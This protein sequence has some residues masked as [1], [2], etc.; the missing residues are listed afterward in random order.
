MIF[1]LISA[2]I[3]LGL[4]V[5][6]HELG[7]FTV[8]KAVGIKVQEFSVGMGPKIFQKRKG[9]TDYSLRGVPIGGYVKMEGE[10]E[11][12]EDERSF[13][14]KPILSRIAVLIAGSFMNFLLAIII[15]TGIFYTIGVVTTDIAGVSDDAPAYEA[16]IEAGDKI[17][18]IDGETART[19]SA[20]QNY[21]NLSEEDQIQV[22]VERGEETLEKTVGVRVDEELNRR[23]IGVEFDVEQSLGAAVAGSFRETRTIVVEIFNFFTRIFTGEADV[24]QE[25]A[26]PVGIVSLV[27]DATRAGFINVALLTAFISINLGIM[28]LLPIPAL[29]GSRILFLLLEA[30]RGKP[31]DPEKEG[32]VH[33]VGFG[34]L[35]FIMLMVTYQDILRLF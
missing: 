12:S 29:D 19:P 16:G 20:V 1:T 7:H 34:L 15:L 17:I 10:D 3:V 8:A 26:G 18:A 4:L 13:S 11:S 30:V 28:N 25:V 6:V 24:S 14:N 23:I 27:G 31:I 33:L 21:I 9:E 5:I 32:M 35:I 22:T 2:A